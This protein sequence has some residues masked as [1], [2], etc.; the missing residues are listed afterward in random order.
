MSKMKLSEI[1]I[2]ENFLNTIPSPTKYQKKKEK[3]LR[4]GRQDRYIVINKDGYL[5]DGYIT[6]LVMKEFGVEEVKV[7]KSKSWVT[8]GENRKIKEPAY[9]TEN[10]TYVWGTHPNSPDNKLYVWR[11]PNGENWKEFTKNIS[12]GDM[13][14]CRAKEKTAPVIIK[15]IQ[16]TDVCPTPLYVKKVCSKRI[17]KGVGNKCLI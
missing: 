10:T 12:V 17:V 7:I 1:K 5:E 11:V 4:T 13:I 9:R 14:Y 3:W 2:R 8:H 15:A 6:Y 16:T